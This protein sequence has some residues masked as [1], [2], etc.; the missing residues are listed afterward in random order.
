[1]G[2]TK[3]TREKIPVH[4]M[5]IVS[6]VALVILTLLSYLVDPYDP[7]WKDY[8][9]SPGWIALRDTLYTYIY[10]LLLTV[11]SFWI[12]R[13]LDG[14]LTWEKKSG[15]RLFVQTLLQT[16]IA[17]ISVHLMHLVYVVIF[18]EKEPS[19]SREELRLFSQFLTSAVILS[20]LIMAGNIGYYFLTNWKKTATLALELEVN[21]AQH[22]QAASEAE[23]YALRLQIDPHFVFNNLSVLAEQILQDQQKGFEYAENFAKVYRYLL[24][25]SKKDKISVAEELKFL[26]S[27][28]FLTRVRIGSGISFDINL[29]QISKDAMIPPMSLQLL[30]ENAIKHN[31]TVKSDPLMIEIKSPKGNEILVS[32][33]LKPLLTHLN[34]TGIGLGNIRDRY[35]LLHAPEV[36]ITKTEK[37]FTVI[38]PLLK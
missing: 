22:K 20:L 4:H 37:H 3:Y 18:L 8:Y 10:V 9:A 36:V 23:L 17:I 1:M 11:I 33:E 6:L 12:D 7:Y 29:A 16:I 27:Y 28:L 19:Y 21:A 13:K 38:L 15:I 14:W 2:K 31:R 30:V 24:V 5:I 25:N 26:E 35:R 32:N 34:G